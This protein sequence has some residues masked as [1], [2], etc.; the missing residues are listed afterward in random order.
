MS[1]RCWVPQAAKFEECTVKARRGEAVSQVME[2][3]EEWSGGRVEEPD[4][5]QNSIEAEA[6][7]RRESSA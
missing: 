5:K 2:G 1:D 3:V 7:S 6:S 4:D